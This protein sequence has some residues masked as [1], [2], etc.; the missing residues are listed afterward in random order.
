MKEAE[1]LLANTQV[2]RGTAMAKVQTHGTN[3]TGSN[4]NY[5]YYFVA[6][7]VITELRYKPMVQTALCQNTAKFDQPC[8]LATDNGL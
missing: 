1:C 7:K 6:H 2:D 4:D 8:L 5:N 3:R